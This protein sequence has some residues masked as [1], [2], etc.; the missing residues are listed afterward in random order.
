MKQFVS[1]NIV[2]EVSQREL[3]MIKNALYSMAA[4]YYKHHNDCQWRAVGAKTTLLDFGDRYFA[5]AE[6]AKKLL[7]GLPF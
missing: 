4:D 3:E 2:L 1:Q 6:E 7:N 5:L